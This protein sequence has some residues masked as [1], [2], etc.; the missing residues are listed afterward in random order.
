MHEPDRRVFFGV[1][2]VGLASVVAGCASNTVEAHPKTPNPKNPT[3]RSSAL[4]P[5]RTTGNPTQ[6]IS[7]GP[8]AGNR[9]ALTIDDGYSDEVVAGYV[10][11]ALRTGI[12]LT[13]SPNGLYA[14]AWAPHA[15]VLRPL[16]ERGQIQIINHTF[17]HPDLRKLT[18]QQI[19]DELERNEDWV[20]RT[21]GTSTRPYYRPPFGA[22]NA[23][24]DGVAAE[25][26]YADTVMWDGTFGDDR[27]ITSEYLMKQASEY[28]RPGVIMLGHA[29]H[30]TVL[31]LFD[32]IMDLIR[33]REL[34]AVTLHEMFGPQTV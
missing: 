20:R 7:R 24:V 8:T 10:N 15:N 27:V 33:K 16:I 28:L 34:D 29:N 6:V 13:F 22:H 25:L 1:L 4:K 11:F 3:P 5:A 26:G 30:P 18:D 19:R 21:F 31:G 32:Q 12:H 2:A 17:N 23:Q 9:I 14:H